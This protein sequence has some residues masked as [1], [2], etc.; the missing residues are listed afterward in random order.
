MNDY[1]MGRIAADRQEGTAK[2][3]DALEVRPLN[4]TPRGRPAPITPPPH[5][6]ACIRAHRSSRTS[7]V[8][9]DLSCGRLSGFSHHCL[10]EPFAIGTL[11][12]A[13]L[14]V[15]VWSPIPARS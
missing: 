13:A 10:R 14:G 3:G 2:A 5:H 8:A 6:S 7:G 11:S 1:L 12:V 9:P 4:S 15:F